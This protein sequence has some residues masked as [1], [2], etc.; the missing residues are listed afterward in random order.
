MKLIIT[1]LAISA[2][3]AAE[4]APQ[5]KPE[6][7]ADV[8]AKMEE[9]HQL[10]EAHRQ[11]MEIKVGEL[12]VILENYPK[13]RE[14]ILKRL[15]ERREDMKDEGRGLGERRRNGDRERAGDKK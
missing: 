2:M 10:R 14:H 6:L 11:A 8:K 7:P 5:P 9:I 15:E 13:L 1:L 3:Y 12:K 4:V